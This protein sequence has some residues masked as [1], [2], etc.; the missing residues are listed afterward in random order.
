[1][2]RQLL[3]ACV[4]LLLLQTWAATV[5]LSYCLR[6]ESRQLWRRIAGVLLSEEV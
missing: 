1:M 5:L 3:V 2:T 4:L 6:K